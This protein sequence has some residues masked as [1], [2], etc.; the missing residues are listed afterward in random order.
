MV[1][2]GLCT[3]VAAACVSLHTR[4]YTPGTVLPQLIGTRGPIAES[5]ASAILEKTLGARSQADEAL[6]SAVRQNAGA[7]LMTGNRVELLIDGPQTFAAIEKAIAGAKHSV[8]VEVYIYADDE[9]GQK[10]TDLLMRKRA[11]GVEVRVLYDAIGS[12][13]T[14]GQLFARMRDAGIEVLA[15][16]PP[17]PVKTPL[18]WKINNRDHRKIVVV[19]G[20]IGFTGGVNVSGTYA[21]SSGSSSGGKKALKSGW[22]DTHVQIEGPAVSQLQALFLAGWARAGGNV[23]GLNHD[24]VFPVLEERG[25]DLVATIANDGDDSE[26]RAMYTCEMASIEHAVKSIWLTQAYFAPN[27][28][29][30]DALVRAKQRGVDV[31][32]IVPG[33]TDSALIFHASRA[34]YAPLL[35]GGVKIY[36]DEKSLL[37]AKTAVIDGVVSTVGSANFDMRSFIHN[38]EASAVIVSRPL[39]RALEETFQHDLEQTHEITLHDWRR[40]PLIDR[41]KEKLSSVWGYWL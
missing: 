41:L 17:N 7:P 8:H 5:E 18:L 21:K 37:H 31:R 28:E 4:P 25:S 1:T 30:V 6:V 11:E 12:L 22:R 2:A 39:G 26:N 24:E 20:K 32:I 27:A 35:K 38:N 23:E 13:A 15:F 14:S 9:L 19:D 10:F 3:V 29:L 33:F 34:T 16:R 36:E 40:R